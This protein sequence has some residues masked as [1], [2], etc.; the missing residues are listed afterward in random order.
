MRLPSICLD[1]E[2]D[3]YLTTFRSCFSKPQ[4]K[5]FVTMLLGL[6][7]CQSEHTLSNLLRQVEQ[8]SSL[9]SVSRFLSES[10]WSSQRLVEQWLATFRAKMQPQVL[11]EHAR[12]SGSRLKRRGR[13]QKTVVTGYLI[14]DDSTLHKRRGKQMGGM[15]HHHSSSENKR[16]PGHCLVQALYV[17]QGRRCPLEPLMYTQNAVCLQEQRPFRSKIEQ[18][19]QI[20]NDFEPVAGTQT[21]VLLDSWYTAKKIWRAARARDF[22]ITSGLKCNRHLRIETPDADKAWHWQR[23]DDYA[24]NLTESDFTQTIWP[25]SG[26]PVYVHVVSTRVKKLYRCQVIMV[27]EQLA[28]NTRYWASSDL[29]ADSQILLA[30][31]ARR[32]DVEQLFADVKALLGIDHY[33]LMSVKSIQR[34]WVLVMLAYTYLDQQRDRLQRETGIHTTIGDAWRATQQQHQ[35]HLI[36]WIIEAVTVD[37]LTAADLY[38]ELVA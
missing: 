34:F 27:R 21:H 9:A 16:V 22:H 31:I 17:L 15:G 2:L 30:Y 32:W 7:L 10:P 3:N 24:A 13:P 6:L 4:Y 19:M 36:D 38:A 23:V 33:Q 18:M 37:K 5:H 1:D 14:G 28:G 11:A 8:G 29:A 12:Q 20:I 35:K 25:G 26:R